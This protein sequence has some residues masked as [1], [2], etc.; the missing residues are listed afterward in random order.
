MSAC[1]NPHF[2][3]EIPKAPNFTIHVKGGKTEVY[4]KVTFLDN[5]QAQ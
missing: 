5:Y 3:S 2:L 1:I 4:D